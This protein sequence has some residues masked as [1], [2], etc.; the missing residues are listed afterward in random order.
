VYKF[1]NNIHQSY[2]C[3]VYVNKSS[4]YSDIRLAINKQWGELTPLNFLFMY[5]KGHRILPLQEQF[6]ALDNELLVTIY[7]Q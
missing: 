6:T 3:G 7:E 1:E 4:T 2:G 5:K